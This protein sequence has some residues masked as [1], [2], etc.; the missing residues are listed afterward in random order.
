MPK[1]INLQEKILKTGIQKVS[2]IEL[3]AYILGRLPKNDSTVSEA[4]FSFIGGWG[5]FLA[6]EREV[7]ETFGR[8]SSKNIDTIL[9][10]QTLAKRM[11]TIENGE[12]YAENNEKT[13]YNG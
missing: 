2:G 9:A 3:L 11:E 4:L 5:R 6:A 10:I 7:F 8:L 1:K 12:K 13:P